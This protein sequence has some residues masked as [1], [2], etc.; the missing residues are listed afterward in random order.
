MREYVGKNREKVLAYQRDYHMKNKEKEKAQHRQYC[1]RNRQKITE[2]QRNYRQKNRDKILAYQ[3]KHQPLQN[4]TTQIFAEHGNK[5]D[6]CGFNN[7]RALQLH[8]V[9]GNRN[10]TAAYKDRKAMLLKKIPYMV[11]CAN[12]HMI[13]HSQRKIQ[14]MLEVKL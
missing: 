7:V 8:H 9:F 6:K 1:Q 12:C 3:R 14:N 10:D 5:C 4:V 11:L 2:H 13:L